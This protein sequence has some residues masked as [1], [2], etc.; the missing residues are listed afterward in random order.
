VPGGE[1]MLA[2]LEF[3]EGSVDGWLARLVETG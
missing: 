3:G 1:L 2:G